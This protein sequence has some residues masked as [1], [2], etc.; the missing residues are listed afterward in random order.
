MER[1]R[2]DNEQIR[3]HCENRMCLHRAVA[4]GGPMS[5]IGDRKMLRRHVA[6]LG[7]L[8]KEGQW[9]AGR[10]ITHVALIGGTVL[11]LT[12]ATLEAKDITIS[13]V[14]AVGGV[15]VSVPPGT[16]VQLH[17]YSIL[18]GIELTVPT[19]TAIQVTGFAIF[20]SRKDAG[21]AQ[22]LQTTAIVR[23]RRFGLF[24]GI[25]VNRI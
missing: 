5:A 7:G 16:D 12:G 21:A 10:S 4:Y 14:V 24:G 17:V 3:Q 11:D 18:G 22:A 20:G 9:Q 2:S 6:L 1:C 15:Q 13:S 8:H 19:T 23:I 25:S